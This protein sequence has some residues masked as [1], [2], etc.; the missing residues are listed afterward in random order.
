MIIPL[1]RSSEQITVGAPSKK[2]I[3]NSGLPTI[4]DVLF[5]FR[6]ILCKNCCVSSRSGAYTAVSSFTV[7]SATGILGYIYCPNA[8]KAASSRALV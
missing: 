6:E 1:M 3:P 8:A 7:A 2:H 4:R 5:D